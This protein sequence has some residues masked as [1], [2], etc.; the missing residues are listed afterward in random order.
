MKREKKKD[1]NDYPLL[2][3][4]V[5]EHEKAELV[6]LIE[7][8]LHDFDDL[9]EFVVLPVYDENMGCVPTLQY[10]MKE[11]FIFERQKLVKFLL[12]RLPST[13]IPVKFEEV[14]SIERTSSGKLLERK[15]FN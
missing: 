15:R 3:F 12:Q 6:K 2:A 5:S 1:P 4:R 11:G 7:E 14:K 13:H 8:V 10:V 9:K